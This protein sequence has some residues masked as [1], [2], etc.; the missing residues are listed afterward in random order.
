M[1]NG[2]PFGSARRVVG[3]G[4]GETERVGQ[5]GLEFGFPGAATSSHCCRQCR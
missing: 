2:V 5:L 1:L 4:E 3:H